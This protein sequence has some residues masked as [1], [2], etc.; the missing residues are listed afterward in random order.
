MAFII[1]IEQKKLDGSENVKVNKGVPG[2][3]I[4]QS[5]GSTKIYLI[6][7]NKQT[8]SFN[9]ECESYKFGKGKPCKHIASV[10]K[11]YVKNAEI[12]IIEE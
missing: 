1:A 7:F 12:K 11:K 5:N 3:W 8:V 2:T 10:V 6:K 4:A 9:C